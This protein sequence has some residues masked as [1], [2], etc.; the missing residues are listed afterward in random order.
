MNMMK[1]GNPM[2][3]GNMMKIGNIIF[4]EYFEMLGYSRKYYFYGT[5]NATKIRQ[6]F[7]LASIF[8]HR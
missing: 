3:T 2:K 7:Y 5:P 8:W 1:T 4:V 6:N